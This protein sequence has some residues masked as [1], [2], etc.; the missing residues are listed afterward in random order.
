MQQ[1]CRVHKGS[2]KFPPSYI[3]PYRL[4][5]KVGAAAYELQLPGQ[6]H[7]PCVPHV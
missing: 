2:N 5:R 7:S 4:I 1:A 3:G 6:I